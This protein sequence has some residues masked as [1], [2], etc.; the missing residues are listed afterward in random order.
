MGLAGMPLQSAVL[1]GDGAENLRV[2]VDEYGRALLRVNANP[3]DKGDGN[4]GPLTLKLGTQGGET[5]ISDPFNILV[6]FSEHSLPNNPALMKAPW[7][8]NQAPLQFSS[9]FSNNIKSVDI[10]TD[11]GDSWRPFLDN[12]ELEIFASGEAFEKILNI[13]SL[14]DGTLELNLRIVNEAN[15]SVIQ[16]FSVRKDT[17]AP[18]AR[19][20]TPVTGARVN[21]SI[22]IGILIEEAGSL[23]SVKY[24]RPP[25]EDETT[26][27]IE[28][29]LVSGNGAIRFLDLLTDS[30]AP[31]DE[32][33][34][35]VFED[36]AGNQ[37]ELNTIPFI[38]DNDMDIPVLY[39]TLPLENEV[40]VNDF[41]VSGVMYDD[42]G[43]RQIHWRIDDGDEQIL[44]AEN[45]FSIPVAISSLSD[46]EHTITV[47][48]EDI[49]GVKS[50]PVTRNFRVSLAE[51][52]GSITLP[53]INTIVRE[54]VRISGTASDKN[55][56]A[57]VQISLDNGNTFNETHIVMPGIDENVSDEELNDDEPFHPVSAVEWYHESN[58]RILKDG[59]HVIFIKVIDNYG[60]S[61]VYSS[62]INVDN[63][64]PDITLASPL[65]GSISTGIV[66]ISG[67]AVDLNLD[68]IIIEL[69]NLDGD[70]IPE[71]L[72]TYKLDIS[73]IILKQLDI[74]SLKDGFYNIEVKA[75][76]RAH[77]VTRVSRN[78]ELARENQPNFTDILYPLDGE[79]AQGSFNL[80]GI[81]G[82]T[83]AAKTVTLRQ[84]GRVL[85]VC[86]VSDDGYFR[87]A[88]DN[89]LLNDGLNKL[90]VLSNFGG[91]EEVISPEHSIYYRNDGAWVTID[92]LDLGD[93]AY[94]RPWLSGRAGYCLSGSDIEILE[95]RKSDK[96]LRSSIQAKTVDC[97]EISF[98][99]GSTF[100]KAGRGRSKEFDWS[101]RLE[102][103]DM[104]EG[105][106]YIIVRAS[107]KNGE[108]AVSR[109]LVQ[110][111]KTPPV[112]R[113]IAPETGGRYNQ[114][115]EFTA[116]ASDNVELAGLSYH[117]RPGDKAAY[118]IPGFIQGLYF[119]F[120]IP[121]FIKQIA[122]DS[123][124]IFNGGATYMDFGMG[125]SF[126]EDNVKVQLQY[127]FMTPAIYKSMGGGDNSLRY[128]GSVLG[129]KL[130]ANLYTLQ[131]GSFAGPDWDWLSASFALG[132]NFSLFDI[133]RQNLTQ[134][135]QPTWISALVT[136]IE[137]PKVTIPKR[138]SLRT[139]SMFTEGQLWFMTT[140]VDTSD[141]LNKDIPIVIPS[142]IVGL[143][144]YI[145]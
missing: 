132:A 144:M 107:M 35:F 31:L 12:E 2:S 24:Q 82:G 38:I 61:A 50:D 22:R 28:K 53:D 48:A 46:N 26:E 52:F 39:I 6:D 85:S 131:F 79:Y 122:N 29:I 37:S 60:I 65:D 34:N 138:T 44:A 143:R 78:I 14:P 1:E 88:L 91:S 8:Q 117:L 89:E 18:Q 27:G 47:I 100:I 23:K 113:L 104:N 21:G 139:F 140:D 103:G 135:N 54:T 109:T 101:Y 137:F 83:D 41:V 80:Y 108:T 93:F 125:L 11:L 95:D 94:E 77:N 62:I 10:S 98:D 20:I 55:G 92:S 7:V 67:R 13:A 56:I 112:I 43:I 73:S 96:E 57:Q 129:I 105:K 45:G 74:S 142:L 63:N 114:T 102:T 16:R 42:D 69:R 115:L 58:S 121:P 130:L 40:I 134:S 5:F 33:M 76:D 72:R 118:E 17:Q 145:F 19:F 3:P 30:T 75:S 136:Q 81:T 90:T 99:N 66:D 116:L 106:H 124:S 64:P 71:D 36:E 15:A 97:I 141:S 123:L 49:F 84:E 9:S 110:V 126:F 32:N 128:G 120:T 111:D 119:E 133:A 86:N 127:G 25:S 59:T 4:F 68:E 87:F 51:P 70:E